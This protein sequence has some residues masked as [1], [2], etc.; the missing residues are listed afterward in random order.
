M[1]IFSLSLALLTGCSFFQTTPQPDPPSPRPVDDPP[2]WMPKE[3]VQPIRWEP[4]ATTGPIKQN[5][6]AE[7][8]VPDPPKPPPPPASF[9]ELIPTME[10]IARRNPGDTNLQVKLAA[11]Y[12][13]NE[14][15]VEAQAVFDRLPEPTGGDS[16]H[17]LDL[18]H[19]SMRWIVK[20]NLGLRDADAEFEK[21]AAE[22]ARAHGMGIVKAA[23][24]TKVTGF[25]DF[26]ERPTNRFAPGEQA[27][28][29]LQVRNFD[30]KQA[31]GVYRFHLKYKWQLL[32]E[33]NQDRTPETWTD[34]PPD[35][36]EDR[37]TLS[38]PRTE[39][40]QTFA[41]PAFPVRAGGK[42]TIR[43]NVLDVMRG[44]HSQSVDIPIEMGD[45]TPRHK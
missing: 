4:P 10:A 6:E 11:L 17:R 42:Y 35:T 38:G 15:Y 39:F 44:N 43:I 28:I 14:Q 25:E 5:V 3:S 8:V 36:F 27:L 29:Y 40:W 33:L 23:L 24:C 37:R 32:D 12:T 13:L 18:V 21:M 20:R 16:W 26:E 30:L 19:R 31:D 22:I 34:V 7:A 41:L 45:Y 1:R 2:T 9:A